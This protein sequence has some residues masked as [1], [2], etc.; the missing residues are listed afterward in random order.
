MSDIP[1]FDGDP[2][3]FGPWWLRFKTYGNVQGWGEA[4]METPETNLPID[5]VHPDRANP[6]AV[7]AMNANQQA[8]FD[9][10]ANACNAL[11]LALPDKLMMS[12]VRASYT[13]HY[14]QGKIH[15]MVEKLFRKYRLGTTM[16]AVTM[17]T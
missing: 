4:L 16:S 3:S 2:D 17:T 9:R 10:N 15:L 5:P 12:I 13:D 6:A 1:K 14:P 11:P 7:A 8:A